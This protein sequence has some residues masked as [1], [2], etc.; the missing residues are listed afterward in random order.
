MLVDPNADFH[1]LYEAT[2]R[3]LAEASSILVTGTSDDNGKNL[4]WNV[5]AS[6][7]WALEHLIDDAHALLNRM[8]KVHRSERYVKMPDGRKVP[9]D[10]V[11]ALNKKAA[12]LIRAARAVHE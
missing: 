12:E 11:L 1:D 4:S 5:M 9:M 8:W 3:H 6:T 10:D 7:L 2:S